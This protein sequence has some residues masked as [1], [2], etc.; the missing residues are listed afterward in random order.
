M[1]KKHVKRHVVDQPL[2]KPYRLIALT[3]GQNAIVDVAD[4][5]WL[6]EF[7]WRAQWCQNT[8]SFYARRDTKFRGQNLCMAAQILECGKG[9]FPDHINH[10][11]LDHRR[12]NLRK[13]T[14]SQNCSNRRTRT[15][16][17][18]GYRGVWRH[19]KRWQTE[20]VKEGVSVFCGTFSTAEEAARAY[21]EAAKKHHGEFA[22]LNFP[23]LHVSNNS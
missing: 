13:A 12:E 6:S 21:D 19:N 2:D 5:D 7:N 3:Q 1:P 16:N 17:T 18:S 20:V 22:Q 11:T 8:C 9:E 4:F 15:D 23:N 14:H 10:D